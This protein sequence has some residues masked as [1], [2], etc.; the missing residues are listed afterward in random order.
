MA[1]IDWKSLLGEVAPT[2]AT[3]LGGPLAG[4][5]AMAIKRAVLGKEEA[6]EQEVAEALSVASPDVLLALR[7]ADNHF[8]LEMQRAGID[9]EKI[10]AMDRESARKREM[11]LKDK[12]PAIL[13]TLITIGF[14]GILA[15]LM[16]HGFSDSPDSEPLL[17]MLGSLGTAWG[18]VVNY[19]FG[20]SVGSKQK[21]MMMGGGK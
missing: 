16:I 18:G 10:A 17:I 2:L 20:S 13:A 7:E 1:K 5:A 12:T 9:L 14:F 8:K 4:A 6:T 15:Y 3:A 11:A 21:T 19:Y